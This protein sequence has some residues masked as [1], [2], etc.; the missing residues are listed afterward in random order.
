M[1]LRD[2]IEP[3]KDEIVEQWLAKGLE[4]YSADA[5]K[6]FQKKNNRFVNPVGDTLRRGVG[7]F[8]DGLIG[9]EPPAALCSHLEEIVQIRSV[10]QMPPSEALGFVMRLKE[11]VR[12]VS[13]KKR[14]SPP[15]LEKNLAGLASK[16]DATSLQ[17]FDLYIKYRERLFD[18]RVNDVKRQVS[19]LLKRTSFFIND[20]DQDSSPEGDSGEMNK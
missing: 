11:V 8:V 2:L 16:I 7:A 3:N 15:E 4:V 19:H 18:I 20:T 17:L 13:T 14:K 9:D 1:T 10:Q 5:R 6:F 12:D